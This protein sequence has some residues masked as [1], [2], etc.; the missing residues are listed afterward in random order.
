MEVSQ[1]KRPPPM[2]RSRDNINKGSSSGENG[3]CETDKAEILSGE[4]A[5]RRTISCLEAIMRN[6]DSEECGF[7]LS[8][9]NI[10]VGAPTSCLPLLL[11]EEDEE[12]N[13]FES[14]AAQAKRCSYQILEGPQKKKS[15]TIFLKPRFSMM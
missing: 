15:R 6:D 5:S 2:K 7:F 1:A 3:D 9:P 12:V 10:G 13:T 8:V 11:R 4:V 14:P